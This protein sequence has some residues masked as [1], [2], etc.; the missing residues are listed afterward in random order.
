MFPNNQIS[1]VLDY[2]LDYTR[3]TEILN[4]LDPIY[5]LLSLLQVGLKLKFS[6]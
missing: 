6:Y 4:L 1:I 3:Q 2:L 5:S